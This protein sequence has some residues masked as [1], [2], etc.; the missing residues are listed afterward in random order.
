MACA[1]QFLAKEPGDPK[2]LEAALRYA[3]RGVELTKGK[4]AS[5][6]YVL[7]LAQFRNGQTRE[8]VTVQ[9]RA[10]AALPVRTPAATRKAWKKRLTEY[11][12]ALSDD[13]QKP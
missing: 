2:D 11:Q 7:A 8:A 12:E 9:R 4:D 10:I 3:R 5:V 6:L 1:T 13:P